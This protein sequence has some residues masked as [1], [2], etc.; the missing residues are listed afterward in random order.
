M[1]AALGVLVTG[2]DGRFAVAACESLSR[3]GYRVGTVSSEALAP[4]AWSRFTAARFRATDP[5]ASS[6]RFAEDVAAIAQREGFATVIFGG[7]AGLVAASSHREAFTA[8]IDLGLPSREVVESCLDKVSLEEGARAVGLGAPRTVLCA[9]PEEARSAAAQLGY[10]LI[11]KP[12]RSIFGEVG[13]LQQ[14]GGT[15]VWDEAGLDAHLPRFGTP[16]LLQG[17]VRGRILSVGGVFAD[18]KLLSVATSRYIRTWQPDAGNV[19]FSTTIEA[20]DGL[21]ERVEALLVTFGWQGV[22]ELELIESPDGHLTAI[23]FNPRL[24]GSLALAVAAGAPLPAVW[25][26]WLLR[27]RAESSI[28]RPGVYYRWADADWRHV[29]GRLRSGRVGSAISVLRRHRRTTHP[30]FRHRDP[31][32]GIVRGAQILRLGIRNGFRQ[33]LSTRSQP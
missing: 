26:D 8:G 25:C 20:P 12:R 1:E 15:I 24:Y 7:D 5:R 32:P 6:R 13:R 17:H 27:G 16:C 22:F 4:A 10:P 29:W 23:D 2:A 21:L 33:R 11:L 30:Y 28:A 19:T 14:E 3:A 18:G 31:I 9:N